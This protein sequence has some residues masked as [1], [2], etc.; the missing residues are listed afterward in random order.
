MFDDIDMSTAPL[1]EEQGAAASATT[2]TT[3]T[4]TNATPLQRDTESVPLLELGLQRVSSRSE[5]GQT[6][7]V[8]CVKVSHLRARNQ[9][10]WTIHRSYRGLVDLRVALAHEYGKIVYLPPLPAPPRTARRA[11]CGHVEED[12][13]AH[14][15][16]FLHKV[17]SNPA[18]REA[19]VTREFLEISRAGSG[20]VEQESNGEKGTGSPLDYGPKIKEGWV[21][22][23]AGGFYTYFQS[24]FRVAIAELV[25]FVLTLYAAFFSSS[26]RPFDNDISIACGVVGVTL[27][28]GLVAL[29]FANYRRV[30]VTFVL[31]VLLIPVAGPVLILAVV[32]WQWIL[33]QNDKR[34][35]VLRGTYLAYYMSPDDHPQRG[36]R[37]VLQLDDPN[38][39]IMLRKSTFRRELTIVGYYRTL[40]ISAQ[41]FRERDEWFERLQQVLRSNHALTTPA[42]RLRRRMRLAT[43]LSTN[44]AR[45][46]RSV[47]PG[48][49]ASSN[50]DDSGGGGATDVGLNVGTWWMS[51]WGAPPP[52]L[53]SFAPPRTQSSTQFFVDAKDLYEDMARVIEG[54]K[55][56]IF[57]ADWMLSP[58]V[59][60]RRP[61]IAS[62]QAGFAHVLRVEPVAAS[63]GARFF[64][65][66]GMGRAVASSDTELGENLFDVSRAAPANPWLAQGLEVAHDE[67]G[68]E[69]P[70]RNATRPF[71]QCRVA[72][73]DRYLPVTSYEVGCSP[74]VRGFEPPSAWVLSGRLPETGE[75]TVLDAQ[76]EVSFE[77][78]GAEPYRVVLDSSK[79]RRCLE[80]RLEFRFPAGPWGVRVGAVRF[81]SRNEERTGRLDPDQRLD[82]LLAKRASEGVRVHVLL[83]REMSVALPNSSGNAKRLLGQAVSRLLGSGNARARSSLVGRDGGLTRD[84][85]DSRDSERAASEMSA[86]DDEDFVLVDPGQLRR[87]VAV[88]GPRESAAACP[89]QVLRHSAAKTGSADV[90]TTLWSHHEK[91]L[92]VDQCVAYVGGLDL[93]FGRFD[94]QT[95]SMT[96]PTSLVW[97]GKD[98]YNV[99]VKDFDD[100]GRPFRDSIHRLSECRMPW[101]DVHCRVEGFAAGD[102][103]KHFV[104]RWNMAMHE[105]G[106]KRGGRSFLLPQWGR[107]SATGAG[108]AAPPPGAAGG[109]VGVGGTASY[110]NCTC[111]IVRSVSPWSASTSVERSVLDAYVSLIGRAEKFVYIE[112][113]FLVSGSG[114]GLV[115]NTVLGA[116]AERLERAVR[117]AAGFRVVVVI[118]AWPAFEGDVRSNVATQSVLHWTFASLRE[119]WRRLR[120]A[121]AQRP[122]DYVGVYS[123]RKAARTPSGRC[124]T[125][126][127]YVH[128]KVMVVDDR[129]SIIGSANINDRSLLGD[130]DSEMCCVAGGGAEVSARMQ[131]EP[132][133]A[134]AFAADLRM[135]LWAE[136]LGLVPCRAPLPPAVRDIV[137]DPFS[138][139]WQDTATRNTRLLQCAWP[140]LPRDEYRLLSQIPIVPDGTVGS[141]MEGATATA[142]AL[143]TARERCIDEMRGSLVHFPVHFL[144]DEPDLLPRYFSGAQ[145]GF[146]P[147]E[148]FT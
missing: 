41:T 125:E 107:R 76:H 65:W 130:R 78:P 75:W 146:V 21:W 9:Q 27:I 42:R 63:R 56:E 144:E 14:V 102:V 38:A 138:S 86:A 82:K 29:H 62:A 124:V 11:C 55:H 44:H 110:V 77:R 92:V 20:L 64:K 43:A 31:P 67:S 103:A 74:R 16:A 47:A 18:L 99:R 37:G 140:D 109:S 33:P 141:D 135:S 117:D 111:Q 95:H 49:L 50:D 121:G 104:W 69:E 52:V 58:E 131:G 19:S 137:V 68:K 114:E 35:L 36:A 81:F 71:V 61:D 79:R 127:I 97:P 4:A 145:E 3:T 118:P 57:I 23:A 45:D 106:S 100:L 128:A 46:S 1:L 116:L 112:N 73:S 108:Q 98:Y 91:L 53:S 8:Y 120:V 24:R 72:P 7:L 136:H 30:D 51:G 34:W 84:G 90:Y 10:P 80:L 123:L 87:S 59:W 139:I 105:R 12:H 54:A 6:S 88:P 32:A 17:A 113:Q 66:V 39:G 5:W 93:A 122:E 134:C 25:I 119:L 70:E 60:L 148:T 94:D 15:Q 133:R 13:S 2:T 83:Y 26:S 142:A 101:H 143:E 126:Q 40:S 129:W 89:I 115:R 85:G 48:D 147:L 132:W 22:K 96:D 28:V